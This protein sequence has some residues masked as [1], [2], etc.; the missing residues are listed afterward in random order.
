M[1]Q[2]L[3][4]LGAMT[5]SAPLKMTWTAPINRNSLVARSAAKQGPSGNNIQ[6][7]QTI[8]AK[9]CCPCTLP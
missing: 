7:S 8:Q 3:D 6:A 9:R 1:N 5:V 4:R 2:K